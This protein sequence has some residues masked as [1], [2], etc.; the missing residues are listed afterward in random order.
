MFPL[1][2][3]KENLLEEDFKVAISRLRKRIKILAV[4]RSRK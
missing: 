1:H 2:R 3:A 4:F